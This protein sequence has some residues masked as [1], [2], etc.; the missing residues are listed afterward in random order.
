MKLTHYQKIHSLDTTATRMP[1]PED[2]SS[3]TMQH[4]VLRMAAALGVPVTI[5]RVPGGLLF[6][7][8]TDKISNRP[9]RWLHDSHP[10]GSHR[11]GPIPANIGAD[12]AAHHHAI[13]QR[14]AMP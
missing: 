6:W 7:R 14:E 1:L 13:T 2:T 12:N 4:R 10:P 8:S 11:K 3:T 5:R 9:D